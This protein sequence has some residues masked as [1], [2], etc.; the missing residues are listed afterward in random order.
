M[1]TD[2]TGGRCTPL[3]RYGAKLRNFVVIHHEIVEA[4]T[5]AAA[6]ALATEKIMTQA[7]LAFEVS[8]EGA[9]VSRIVVP[10]PV[11]VALN[12]AKEAPQALVE[13]AGRQE[14][15]FADRRADHGLQAPSDKG[16]GSVSRLTL[17]ALLISV[18]CVVLS[19][20]VRYR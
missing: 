19:L 11:R 17:V 7:N 16:K 2:G 8:A 9:P 12:A 1:Q 5:E 20:V 4:E 6:A 10:N 14:G 3:P 13:S 15:T 18:T